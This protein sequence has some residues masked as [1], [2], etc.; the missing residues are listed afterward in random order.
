MVPVWFPTTIPSLYSPGTRWISEPASTPC[1]SG[2]GRMPA[3]G[4]TTCSTL[5]WT[6][7]KFW[8]RRQVGAERM[9]REWSEW[10]PGIPSPNHIQSCQYKT[11]RIPE[12]GSFPLPAWVAGG[13]SLRHWYATGSKFDLSEVPALMSQPVNLFSSA[14]DVI[15]KIS[16][17]WFDSLTCVI[18]WYYIHIL[19][20]IP[21]YTHRI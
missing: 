19:M 7:Q 4:A 12:D 21:I 11:F 6:S 14:I 5:K 18:I 16:G 8:V 9:G 20:Y 17:W 1:T 13:F 15:L 2:S 3:A 10:L